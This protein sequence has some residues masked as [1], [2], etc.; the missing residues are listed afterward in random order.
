MRLARLMT[1]QLN[2]HTVF[3][4]LK[5]RGADTLLYETLETEKMEVMDKPNFFKHDLETVVQRGSGVIVYDAHCSMNRNELMKQKQE[6][7]LMNYSNMLHK[8]LK[9]YFPPTWVSS[10]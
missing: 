3:V 1:H 4:P 8:K 5:L 9:N 7:H 2:H 6:N 10:L